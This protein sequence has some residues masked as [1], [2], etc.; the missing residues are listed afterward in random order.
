MNPH[1]FRKY[2]IRGVA[3]VDFAA[4]F[5]HDLGRALGTFYLRREQRK[6]A[7]GRDARLSSP[8]IHDELLRGLLST[9]LEVV[10]LGTVPTPLVYF[11]VFH[12]ELDGGV[13]ITGSHNP[14]PDNGFKLMTGRSSLYG[15]DIQE[16][17]RLMEERD[18]HESAPGR[19]EDLDILPAYTGFL[20]GNIRPAHRELRFALDAGN[21]AAGPTAKAAF[22]ALGFE[23]ECLLCEMNGHFPVHHP[24]P[25]EPENLELLRQAVR[26]KGLDFGIAFDG[27]GDRLGV[28]D[29]EGEI[30]WG[31]KLLTL[32]ARDL[33]VRHPGAAVLG[34]VK[35]SQS[36]Y[37]DIAKRGGRPIL[38]PTGHSLIKAKMK[39]EG[40]LLA[41]EMSGHMFFADRYYGFD[42][43]VY[44]AAR[45]VE[46]LSDGG[47]P[48]GERLDDL[49]DL[50][51]TP[52]IRVEC[53]D[54]L[55]F[56]VVEEVLSHYRPLRDVIDVDGARIQFGGSAW[57]LVRA[58]NTQPVLVLRFEAATSQRLGEIRG[59]VEG[60]VAEIRGRLEAQA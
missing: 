33:L 29:K 49:P 45:L 53:P 7:L 56:Q 3:D 46:L 21:G 59:E 50:H 26:R 32:F 54:H 10:D 42:D 8:R 24:D 28:I 51:V 4:P 14:A 19:V 55:K 58:S 35:C 20:K 43:A 52:E 2:D 31:D 41:G 60:V 38:G 9:G 39:E 1:V 36:L 30:L 6:I 11:A 13:M 44:T 37:D 40:A 25:T 27:D 15:D 22:A 48:V 5:P 16:L 17:H 23:P 57:G 34:E 47:A 18:F 12:L